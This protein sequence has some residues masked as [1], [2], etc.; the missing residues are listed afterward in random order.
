ME[1][2]VD[3]A[4]GDLLPDQKIEHVRELLGAYGS[5]GM[6]GDGVN[7]VPAPACTAMA[8]TVRWLSPLS[9]TTF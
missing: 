9:M 6:I 2:H 8:L 7:D 5:V 1:G 4:H 3:E